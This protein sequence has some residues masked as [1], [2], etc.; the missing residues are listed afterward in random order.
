MRALAIAATGMNAQQMNVEVIANN[1]A[2]INTTGFKRAR[3]EFTDLLY[4]A[5]KLQGVPMRGGQA[6]VPEGAQ[7]G[8]GVKAAAIR[9]LHMQGALTN[10]AIA[11]NSTAES[12]AS[13]ARRCTHACLTQYNDTAKRDAQ[14]THAVLKHGSMTTC[15]ARMKNSPANHARLSS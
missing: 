10:T 11:G 13:P 9:N 1:I 7:I 14:C 6:A 4:Q 8:L 12:L 15:S 3:A 5:E 2:N